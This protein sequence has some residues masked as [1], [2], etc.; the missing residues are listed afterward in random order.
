MK[1]RKSL[2]LFL[3]A[4]GSLLVA[5]G[6]AAVPALDQRQTTLDED[7]TVLI[8]G[9][10]PQI[11]GQVVR[12]GMAGLLTRVD[13]PIGCETP[14]TS[15]VVQILD[16]SDRPGTNVL[17]SH[18]V[19][20][21]TDELDWTS[22]AIPAQPFIPVETPF[23][24]ALSSPGWCGI[25]SGEFEADPYPRG[26]GWY[27]GPP[28][29]PG[30]W[31]PA[32]VD[33]GFKTYVE[34]MCKVPRIL[35]LSRDEAQTLIGTYGCTP[36]TV[37]P[38]HSQTVPQGQVISQEQAEGTMLPPRS[39]VDFAVSLGPRPCRVPPVRGRKLSVARAAIT[40]RACTVGK[41]TRVRSRKVRRGKVVSQSPRAGTALPN[42]GKVNLVVSRG[43]TR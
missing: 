31:A 18:T 1:K 40:R 37:R 4:V 36:G 8:G 5:G 42:L 39:R 6:A 43:P 28:Y 33:L 26:S 9:D 12:A 14:S 20:G 30:F 3:L 27:Q 2:V 23:A 16:A 13:L 29:P 24:I 15:L 35:E 11:P 17:A 32:G 19:S 38:M 21:L 25:V 41:V 10:G 34:R 22:I 7:F